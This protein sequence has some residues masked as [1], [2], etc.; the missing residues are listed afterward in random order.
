MYHV[1][2][3]TAKIR[4]EFN[5]PDSAECRLWKRYMNKNTYELLTKADESVL[6]AGLLS[7]TGS[8]QVS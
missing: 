5:V 6:K 7:V 8:G 3:V 4:T 1:G 2:T